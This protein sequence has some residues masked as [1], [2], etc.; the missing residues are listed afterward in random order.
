MA[1][2]VS[3]L[4]SHLYCASGGSACATFCV[5]PML[6]A[7]QRCNNTRRL[8]GPGRGVCVCGEFGA[9]SPQAFDRNE[10][11]ILQHCVGVVPLHRLVC[12]AGEPVWG[13]MGGCIATCPHELVHSC[14]AKL[15]PTHAESLDNTDSGARSCP[16]A[17]VSG[18]VAERAPV[19]SA[20]L[21]RARRHCPEPSPPEWLVR[22]DHVGSHR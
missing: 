1:A 18:S 20:L 7:C 8:S 13:V 3:P 17:H 12:W 4:G 11:R 22:A 19:Q 9:S 16:A 14:E 21:R 5:R 15:T 10:G 2:R 6:P